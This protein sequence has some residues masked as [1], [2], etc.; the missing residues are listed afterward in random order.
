MSIDDTS[1]SVFIRV[2]YEYRYE[3]HANGTYRTAWGLRS[4][5]LRCRYS[6]VQ[7][8]TWRYSDYLELGQ[9]WHIDQA[10]CYCTLY[11]SRYCANSVL[12]V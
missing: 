12:T 2:S 8:R 10:V 11:S 9:R 1:V 4:A 6:T 3:H 7:Y 5:E